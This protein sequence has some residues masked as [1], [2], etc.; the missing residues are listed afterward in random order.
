ME[1]EPLCGAAAQSNGMRK[2]AEIGG[3]P[4]SKIAEVRETI[5]PT[6]GHAA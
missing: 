2:Q 5:D 3:F 6:T 1:R 4:T